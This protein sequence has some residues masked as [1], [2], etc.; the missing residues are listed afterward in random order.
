MGTMETSPVPAFELDDLS[1]A[2]LGAGLRSGQFTARRLTEL[3]LERIDAIDRNGPALNAVIEVNPDALALA[4]RSDAERADGRDRGPL[5]G[6][7]ILI[8]D[9]IATADR[10]ETTAGSLALVGAKALADAPVVARLRHAGAILLGKTNLSEW[11]NFRSTRS[12]SGWSGRGGQTRNP[13]ALDRSPSGSSS[14]SGTAA[15]ASLAAATVGTETDG[16]ILSPCAAQALVGI[17]PTVGLIGRTGIIPISH[18]QDTAGPMARTVHDAALLLGALVGDDPEDPATRASGRIAHTD[19][20]AFLDPNGLKGKRIGVAR[21]RFFGMSPAA[22]RI[23]EDAL[24]ALHDAGAELIDPAD[25]PT[26][27]TFDRTEFEILLY[28]FKAGLD[29]YLTGLAPGAPIRSLK[30]LIAFNARERTRELPFFDQ[31]ILI[32]AQAKG[33]L[34]TAA[35][36]KALD[37][38]RTRSQD[39]GIDAVMDRHRLDALFAPTQGPA[40]LVDFA[41][42]DATGGSSTGAAAV[43]GYPSI[44]VPAGFHHGLP[45]GVSFFGRAWSESTLIAIACGFEQATQARRPPRFLPTLPFPADGRP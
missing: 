15:A 8:K 5:H 16:S 37:A 27:Y 19:Y 41:N 36:K 26:V 23:A 2:Q 42:G 7:P 33:A 17:K 6:I 24:M 1:L 28:E 40:W 21:K 12:V 43:A 31:E 44:T 10:M 30:D 25:M 11:A 29:T 38:C 18:T 13:Y 22:D 20:T 45:V 14:G 35:Y 3:Y 34:S 39:D 9:N 4:A 32:L